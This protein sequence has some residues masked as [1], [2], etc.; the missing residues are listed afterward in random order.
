MCQHYK[1]FLQ[2]KP[3]YDVKYQKT[4]VHSQFTY[5]CQVED[6]QKGI[7]KLNYDKERFN[8]IVKECGQCMI[9][10]AKRASIKSCQ[11]QCEFKTT[12]KGTFITLTFGEEQ[13]KK[14]IMN[15]KRY[16]DWSDY[17]KKKYINYLQW[18]VEKRE[19]PLFMKR[20]RKEYLNLEK[21][22]FCQK[23]QLYHLLMTK[24][25]KPKKYITIPKCFD[26]KPTKIRFLHSAEYGELKSRP[27]H[28]C[29][30]LGVNFG[31]DDT[32]M[33]YSW[34]QKKQ[35]VLHHNNFLTKLWQFGEVTV[36]RVNYQSINYV[37]RYVTKKTFNDNKA[38]KKIDVAQTI[39]QG[40]IAEYCSQSNRRGLG[41]QYFID[42]AM[43]IIKDEHL[44][45]TNMS[46][47]F[48]S[49]PLPN[50]YKQLM[51]KYYPQQY[52]AYRKKSLVKQL[53]FSS[54]TP[55]ELY[56]RMLIDR[57]KV[58]KHHIKFIGNYEK[59][60]KSV[61]Q[62]K[63]EI[64]NVKKKVFE[65]YNNISKVYSASASDTE[66]IEQEKLRITCFKNFE[67]YRKCQLRYLLNE[68]VIKK[69]N[70][71]N[72]ANLMLEYYRKKQVVS[73]MENPFTAENVNVL[74][75]NFELWRNYENDKNRISL[76][77]KQTVA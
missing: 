62:L 41:Y 47:E 12:G 31:F 60:V 40:R 6:V 11:A 33:R 77:R 30:I 74:R 75:P 35:V 53:E 7:V 4:G 58:K 19:F 52:R 64:F 28:H 29:I 70:R 22:Q 54:K 45:F 46:G 67:K 15:D 5:L 24:S 17:K 43:K 49:V 65:D 59:S 8:L 14:Y 76:Y 36:D 16:K 66:F 42:N 20:L 69:Y 21:R 72:Q 63:Y 48:K 32:F 71:P 55:E 1:Y 25:G 50:Y 34:K 68:Y 3:E 73:I 10:R 37:A 27:H 18:T 56:S 26:F 38:K 2:V 44:Y 57:E 9:C 23:H 61:S 13:L 39:Y 51:K